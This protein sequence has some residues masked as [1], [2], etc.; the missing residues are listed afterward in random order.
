MNSP[1]LLFS[2][3][4]GALA[5]PAQTPDY[6][7]DPRFYEF[8]IQQN[9]A[10]AVMLTERGLITPQLGGQLARALAEVDRANRLPG[11]KSSANYLDLEQQLIA[12][13]GPEASKIHMG[14]SRNDLGAASERLVLRGELL[15]IFR[16]MAGAREAL[17]KLA[18]D[19]AGTIIPGY[20]HSVQAQPTSLAHYLAA[21]AAALDRDEERLLAAYRR[22]NRS[23]LGAAAFTTSGFPLDRSR[24]AAL[25]G[26]D[27]LVENSYDAIMVSTVD[28][29][30]EVC[31]ALALSAIALGRFAQDFLIQ[32]TDPKP[33]LN[34]R[35]S[36][37][38]HSSI[39]PQKRNPGSVERL[40]MLASAVVGDANTVLL[41][42]HNTPAGEVGDIRMHLVY[43]ALAVTSQ[44][45]QM[46]AVFRE[47]L[48][49]I[50]VDPEVTLAKVNSD[51]SVMTEFA[52][53]L[54]REAGVPF[55]IGHKAA[56]DLA[57]H[58]RKVG[59]TPV[60]WTYEEVAKVYRESTGSELPL[61][62]QQVRNALDPRHFVASRRGIGG[63]QPAETGRMI[64]ESA[65]RVQALRGWLSSEQAR[66]KAASDSLEEAFERLAR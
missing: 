59:R 50:V 3:V 43:R 45:R 41:T 24:L 13:M 62:P 30:A 1:R 10:Q 6:A 16:E 34:L 51:Y 8:L 20:T 65:N 55:R 12:A 27:G 61:S 52:D 4:L 47:V 46:Y 44:A 25:L 14:R 48:E 9:K 17:L 53:T 29:K 42:A 23:P 66:I 36:A 35:D 63:P 5:T 19:N 2:I 21:F 40:R 32:Y 39:M 26:F 15:D 54:L 28:S 49:S 7:K 37:V 31:T 58:G 11:G 38:G 57:A 60:Q 22:L 18:K 56:A 33:G 64:G